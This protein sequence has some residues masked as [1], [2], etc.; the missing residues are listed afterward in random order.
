MSTIP[1][2]LRSGVLETTQLEA[3][4]VVTLHETA[5]VKGTRG[6]PR[7]KLKLLLVPKARLML[8]VLL[9]MVCP[10]VVLVAV[11]ERVPVSVLAVVSTVIVPDTVI[12]TLPKVAVW[13]KVV[14]CVVALTVTTG[15]N[16]IRA[17]MAIVRIDGRSI[18]L[19]G[20]RWGRRYRFFANWRC[21][22]VA[23]DS[24]GIFFPL[25]RPGLSS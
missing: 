18:Y 21:P 8:K 14:V 7:T 24:P 15:I 12:F 22:E 2:W 19:Q 25:S 1:S 4:P 11:R 5:S 16:A 10:V 20:C 23:I 9:N 3:E 6:M 13:L 17:S